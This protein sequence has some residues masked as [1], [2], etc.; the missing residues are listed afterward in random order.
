MSQ[1]CWI[2]SCKRSSC[3]LCHC[4]RQNICLI[5]LKEHQDF[6]VSRL[7]PLKVRITVLDDRVKALNIENFTDDIRQK[8]EQWR[9][10]CHEKIDSFFKQK[11]HELDQRVSQ[12]LDKQREETSEIQSK[13][14]NLIQEQDVTHRDL[15]LILTK[16]RD[17]ELEMDSIEKAPFNVQNR[18][19]KIDER[20]ITIEESYKHRFDISSLPPVY[21]TIDIPGGIGPEAASNNHFLLVYQKPNLCLMDRTLTVVK[22]D[23]WRHGRIT[24]ICWSSATDRFIVATKDNI[25]T[26][27]QNNLSIGQLSIDQKQKWHSCTCFNKSLFLS[28]F[29]TCSSIFEYSLLPS[30]QLIKQWKSPDTCQ[31]D[32]VINQMIYHNET[33]VLLI[34]STLNRILHL[35]LRSSKTLDRLWSLPVNIEKRTM[36]LFRFYSVNGGEWLVADHENSRL[37]LITG[38]G[39]MKATSVYKPV[40]WSCFTFGPDM[41]AVISENSLKFHK[42]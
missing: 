22:Q 7:S 40:P 14:T 13:L 10:E 37:A 29:E 21:K 18:S 11:C 28:T 30:I 3:A 41:L 24:D 15:D 34:T 38:D 32:E 39:E 16:I 17:L 9:V 42:F 33:L 19:L 36:K 23:E 26:V 8:L 6:L 12:K 2:D 4:C 27:D 1:T 25:L 5:H 35:E 31:E 20:W